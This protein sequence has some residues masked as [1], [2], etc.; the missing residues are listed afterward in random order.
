MATNPNESI[1]LDED[2]W[3]RMKPK[4][5]AW[6]IGIVGLGVTSWGIIKSDVSRIDNKVEALQAQLKAIQTESESS[7]NAA[8]RSETQQQ[9]INQKLD[10]ILTGKIDLSRPRGQ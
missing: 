7:R 8:I 9:L 2:R 1:S 6:I 5:L 4:M 3:V 10:L